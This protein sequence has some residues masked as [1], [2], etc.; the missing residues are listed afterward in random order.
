MYEYETEL[1]T[2]QKDAIISEYQI[3]EQFEAKLELLPTLSNRMS[4]EQSIRNATSL[5]GLGDKS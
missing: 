4:Y 3:D 5:I 1:S 2:K